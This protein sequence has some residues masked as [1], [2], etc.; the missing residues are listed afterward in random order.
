MK[1]TI[2]KLLDE[3][4]PVKPFKSEREKTSSKTLDK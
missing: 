1:L 2:E 4:A 3:I